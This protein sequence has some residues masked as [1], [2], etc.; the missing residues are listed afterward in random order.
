M[1]GVSKE[2]SNCKMK[3]WD[4]KN[5][6]VLY[7]EGSLQEN[8]PEGRVTSDVA[9]PAHGIMVEDLLEAIES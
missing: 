6:G 8:D 2:E 4:C 9:L 7:V 5:F 1:W 3:K